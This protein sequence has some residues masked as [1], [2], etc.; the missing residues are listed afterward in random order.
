MKAEIHPEYLE[1][2]IKCACGELIETRSTQ[3]DLRVEICSA[4]HPFY[5]G[6]QK[7][8]DT[9]GRVERFRKKYAKQNEPAP[10]AKRGAKA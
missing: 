5:T 8:S 3:Q 2:T 9:E 10:K 4:C 1:T 7:I 6:T